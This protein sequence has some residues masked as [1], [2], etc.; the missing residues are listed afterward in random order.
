MIYAS[1]KRFV[2]RE[3]DL[4]IGLEFCRLRKSFVDRETDLCTARKICRSV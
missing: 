1:R 3:K 4:S 2:D